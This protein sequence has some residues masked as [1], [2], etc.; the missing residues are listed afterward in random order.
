MM[1]KYLLLPKKEEHSKISS[2]NS[3]EHID[4]DKDGINDLLDRCPKHKE[5][6]DGYQDNDGCPDNDNDNDFIID[7]LDAC[8]DVA[9]TFNNIE[10]WDG[11]PELNKFTPPT[12]LGMI[13]FNSHT[14]SL[15]YN[16]YIILNQIVSLLKEYPQVALAIQCYVDIKDNSTDRLQLAKK[17]ANTIRQYIIQK[18]ITPERVYTSINNK[19]SSKIIILYWYY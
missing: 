16:S 13:T 6:F 14:A 5:D 10:D 4:S 11:C 7:S 9:E 17:R 18:D 15:S 8:P 12:N 3:M 2:T 19:P 1:P